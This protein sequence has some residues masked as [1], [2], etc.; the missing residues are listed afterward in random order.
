MAEAK[1]RIAE[2]AD[3][4]RLLAYFWSP[5]GRYL[6]YLVLDYSSF[7]YNL[8][9]GAV[10]SSPPTPLS[11]RVRGAVLMLRHP[12]GVTLRQVVLLGQR[13]G[14]HVELPQRQVCSV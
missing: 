10:G 8:R 1:D 4:V 9:Y 2:L 6:L 14:K 5:N 3:T 7:G 13:H 12:P 11:K